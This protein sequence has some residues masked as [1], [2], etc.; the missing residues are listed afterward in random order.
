MVP[1][2]SYSSGVSPFSGTASQRI[3]DELVQASG[4]APVTKVDITDK[5]VN[6]AVRNGGSAQ[7]WTWQAGRISSSQAA[8]SQTV[9]R[10]FY[11]DQFALDRI[12][13]ML[14]AAETVAGSR[15]NQELQIL[16]YN[17]GV[18]LISV[19][20]RPETSPV[21]FRPDGSLI[22]TVDFATTVGMTEALSDAVDGANQVLAISYQPGKGLMVD[23]RTGT[24]GILLRRTRPAALPAW[25]VQRR[26]DTTAR[27]FSPSDVSPTV[28]AGLMAQIPVTLNKASAAADLSFTIDMS[29]GRSL[30]TI[31]FSLGGATVITDMSGKDITSQV[32]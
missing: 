30:P 27:E 24:D 11:P 32:R 10:P 2:S 7:I 16:E 19:S 20:T 25:A 3:V 12:P 21:F 23:T 9:S 28:L 26:G 13:Q 15:K 6:V 22:A 14:S 8:S 17:Q 5:Q 18:V 1:S 31:H 4:G 29:D